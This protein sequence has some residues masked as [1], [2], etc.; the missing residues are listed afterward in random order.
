MHQCE[1][2]LLLHRI[3]SP[4]AQEQLH[5]IVHTVHT[6]TH[7]HI[8]HGRIYFIFHV[9]LQKLASYDRRKFIEFSR[10]THSFLMPNICMHCY[11]GHHKFSFS[12]QCFSSPSHVFQPYS[13]AR[14]VA[15]RV[16]VALLL[17]RQTNLN[18]SEI[19]GVNKNCLLFQSHC[20]FRFPSTFH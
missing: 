5:I 20:W 19:Y 1:W 17:T 15:R 9:K 2:K 18:C 13:S 16:A 11:C 3:L 12:F 14:M 7:T 10:K 6:H 8:H 4:V